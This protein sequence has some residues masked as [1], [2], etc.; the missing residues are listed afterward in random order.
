MGTV[1]QLPCGSSPRWSRS[2]SPAGFYGGHLLAKTHVNF[3]VTKFVLEWVELVVNNLPLRII[4]ILAV[5]LTLDR[6]FNKNVK[7]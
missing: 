6:W 2:T 7:H 5:L 3:F 1:Q 4:G